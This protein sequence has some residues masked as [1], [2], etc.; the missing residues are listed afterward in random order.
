MK[1]AI[2]ELLDLSQDFYIRQQLTVIVNSEHKSLLRLLTDLAFVPVGTEN[3][4]EGSSRTEKTQI[5]VCLSPD[6]LCMSIDQ[7][8]LAWF[9]QADIDTSTNRNSLAKVLTASHEYHSVPGDTKNPLKAGIQ[10]SGKLRVVQWRLFWS[11]K[12]QGNNLDPER[13]WRQSIPWRFVRSEYHTSY[14]SQYN[15]I[16]LD[17]TRRVCFIFKLS[18]YVTKYQ[19]NKRYYRLLEPSLS[20]QLARFYTICPLV[21]LLPITTKDT[22]GG[23]SLSAC[24]AAKK[25]KQK[26]SD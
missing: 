21:C 22:D 26:W 19:P 15:N 14:T 12:E 4:T 17:R 2:V 6:F 18:V 5:I 10:K 11:N 16:L 20:S 23:S 25:E 24:I 3:W 9:F 7:E 8:F 13:A 1:S